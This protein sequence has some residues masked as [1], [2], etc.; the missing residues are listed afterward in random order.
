M[1]TARHP[2]CRSASTSAGKSELVPIC[3]HDEGRRT[4]GFFLRLLGKQDTLP[5]QNSGGREHV[6][7]PERYGLEL[8]D[9]AFMAL[10]RIQSQAC[11]GSWNQELNPTLARGK[12]TIRGDLESHALRVELQSHILILYRNSDE[13]NA[14][15]H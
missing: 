14:S 9:T 15:N 12:G 11:I 1:L 5:L 2:I 13:S 7:A 4:P 6:V 8:A 10:W 3:I